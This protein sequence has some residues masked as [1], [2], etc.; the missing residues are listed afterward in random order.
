MWWRVWAARL[1]T[2]LAAALCL[3][4]PALAQA[5]A[6]PQRQLVLAINS[7]LEHSLHA[8]WLELIY[9]DALGRLGYSLTLRPFPSKRA[10]A[11]VDNGEL[12]GEVHRVA[13]YIEAHPALV[14]VA[15]PHFTGSFSAYATSDLDLKPGWNSLLNTSY[16]VEH[17]AGSYHPTREL[18]KVVDPARLSSVSSTVL[19]LRK[20]AGGR[21]DIFIDNEGVVSQALESEEFRNAGIRRVAL[22]EKADAYLFLHAR[23]SALAPRLSAVLSCMRKDGS[24]ERHR[25]LAAAMLLPKEKAAATA[26]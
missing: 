2:M 14:R 8:V 9:R 5:Q 26:P 16:R 22:M 4:P 11:M 3:A 20:L 24:I 25:L 21:T 19:G 23:H 12:D 1:A 7:D 13:S 6:V 10:S 17:R 15:E 18:K